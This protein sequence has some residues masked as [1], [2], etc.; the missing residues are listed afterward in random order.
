[1]VCVADD[2]LIYTQFDTDPPLEEDLEQQNPDTGVWAPM[3]LTGKTVR[4]LAENRRTRRQFGGVATQ[5]VVTVPPG[6]TP[7]A[8][9]RYAL[10]A[11]DL[12][13]A[14]DYIYQWEI[15]SPSGAR[16]TVPAGDEW[17]ELRVARK[18]G[19]AA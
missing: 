12:A 2:P 7:P 17:R 16:R 8:R 1:M 14:G 6:Q 19:T 5:V 15:L 10:Q 18:L 11:A 13:D 9:V 4:L 3:D